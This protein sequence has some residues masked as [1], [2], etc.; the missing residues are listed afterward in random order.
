MKIALLAGLM[1]AAS[2]APASAQGQEVV[3]AS[4]FEQ[5]FEELATWLKEY[6]AW[7]RWFEIWGNRVARNFDDQPLWQRMPRPQPPIWL[8]AECQDHWFPEGPLASACYILRVWDEHP[9]R[10]LQRRDLGWVAV[11]NTVDDKVV[12]SSFLQ[13]VHLTGLWMEAR[14]PATPAYGIVGMQIGVFEAGRFT[15]PAVGIMVVMTPDGNG[16]HTLKPATTVGFGYRLLD[17]VPPFFRTRA[18]LHFNVATVHLLGGTQ[19]V[20]PGVAN[21]NL[22]GLSVSARR[23]R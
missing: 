7:E 12:K 20:L 19:P 16:G 22:F 18:T 14:Y 4:E 8:E 9:L 11:G 1:L 10:I 23:A 13:R 5:R 3:P 21:V 15:L 17:F 6:E 2:I